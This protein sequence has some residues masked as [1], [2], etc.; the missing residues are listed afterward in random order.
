MI[1]GGHHLAA[2]SQGNLYVAQ[3][4]AGMQKLAF[5]GLASR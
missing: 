2:D 1:G 5:K 4:T 3:T